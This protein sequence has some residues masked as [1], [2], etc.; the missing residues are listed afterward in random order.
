M[1]RVFLALAL[2]AGA[3][4]LYFH[5]EGLDEPRRVILALA[6]LGFFWAPES[7]RPLRVGRWLLAV[8]VVAWVAQEAGRGTGG[9]PLWI[10]ASVAGAALIVRGGS[11]AA[12]HLLPAAGNETADGQR[13]AVRTALRLSVAAFLVG[14]V[15]G[16][17]SPAAGALV[18]S[19]SATFFLRY[20]LLQAKFLGVPAHPLSR[21]AGLVPSQKWIVLALFALVGTT[22]VADR[23]LGSRGPGPLL[24]TAAL[25]SVLAG[26]VFVFAIVRAGFPRSF[27]RRASFAAGVGLAVTLTAILVELES[28]GPSR[29]RFFASAGIFFLVVLPLV[30]DQTKLLEDHPRLS[31]L[32]PPATVSAMMAPLT[33]LNGTRWSLP[34]TVFLFA[35][36]ELALVHF[37]LVAIRERAPG[38][39]YLGASI[40]LLLFVFVT[41]GGGGAWQIFFLGFG[42]VLYAVDLFERMWRRARSHERIQES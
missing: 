35:F 15:F 38:K 28:W 14:Y 10:A 27:V 41:G 40:A 12:R 26:L 31:A 3:V 39:L 20:L 19:V 22:G 33:A 6:T 1:R 42:L 16:G 30:K 2:V 34:T 32:V 4:F 37:L 11:R 18:V 24:V 8:A 9:L 36:A 5:R 21:T 29:Y 7:S 17:A 25:L 23:L 13:S